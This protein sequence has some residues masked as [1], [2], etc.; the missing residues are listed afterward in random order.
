ML[1]ELFLPGSLIFGI[2][3]GLLLAFGLFTTGELHLNW[4]GI[5]LVTFGILLLY[6]ELQVWRRGVLGITGIVCFIT[7]SV[8]FFGGTS[9]NPF[10]NSGQGLNVWIVVVVSV[11]LFGL[12]WVLIKDL[13]KA[14]EM[15]QYIPTLASTIVGL[16]GVT[17]SDLSPYGT[18]HVLGENWSAVSHTGEVIDSGYPV[19]VEDSEGILL[20]VSPVH[21]S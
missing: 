19:Y 5:P 21:S 16:K 13:T 17:T 14:G 3:G 15:T 1:L 9:L 8:L 20:R 11:S 6:L 18:V 7:G 4:Y 12:L 10:N 2:L